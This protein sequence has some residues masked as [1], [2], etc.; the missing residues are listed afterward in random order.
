MVLAPAAPRACCL[1][2]CGLHPVLPVDAVPNPPRSGAPARGAQ[3]S[4]SG[5]GAADEAAFMPHRNWNRAVD[6][7]HGRPF[8]GLRFP[9]IAGRVASGGC[10]LRQSFFSPRKSINFYRPGASI[11]E[12]ILIE[13]NRLSDARQR[14]TITKV[15]ATGDAYSLSL[16]CLRAASLLSSRRSLSLVFVDRDTVSR[17]FSDFPEERVKLH[18]CKI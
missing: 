10:F 12:G 3:C 18:R 15:K 2:S 11:R 6:D 5:R 1:A 14:C 8:R 9:A 13:K 17:T 16:T 4:S 7:G